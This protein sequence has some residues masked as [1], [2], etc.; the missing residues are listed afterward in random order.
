MT[1][2][3][4]QVQIVSRVGIPTYIT[5]PLSTFASVVSETIQVQAWSNS[6]QEHQ[7]FNLLMPI[8]LSDS[9]IAMTRLIRKAIADSDWCA[10]DYVK[11]GHCF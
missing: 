9:K 1:T 3:T 10:I 8:A 5:H 7:F 4:A 6:K 11:S 2:S